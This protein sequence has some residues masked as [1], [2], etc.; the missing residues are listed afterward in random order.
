MKWK[1]DPLKVAFLF[2]FGSNPYNLEY[3]LRQVG[4][5]SVLTGNTDAAFLPK[6]VIYDCDQVAA[7]L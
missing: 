7:L 3:S 2:R 6:E 1:T 4:D 5:H